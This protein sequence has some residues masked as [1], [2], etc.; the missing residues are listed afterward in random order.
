MFPGRR[1]PYARSV[2]PRNWQA[3]A[4]RARRARAGRLAR[5]VRSNRHFA[6]RLWGP[7]APLIARA[8]GSVSAAPTS[9]A[10][11]RAIARWQRRRGFS[12][13]NGV[14]S[15][16]MWMLLRAQLA[17]GQAQQPD[18]LPPQDPSFQD[19]PGAASGMAGAPNGMD[20]PSGGTE[21]MEPDAMAPPAD[22]MP[23][24]PAADAG[25]DAG[26]NEFGW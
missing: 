3:L 14:L 1:A 20:E 13:V 6:Q 17:G 16:E 18:A 10:F 25:G 15:P 23:D 12:T 7:H 5:A 8:L 2:L 22:A 21:P 26:A 24:E 11:A 4:A 19:T 9:L